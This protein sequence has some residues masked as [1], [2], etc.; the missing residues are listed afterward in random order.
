VAGDVDEVVAVAEP[1][2]PQLRDVPW[3]Q[4][5]LDE[6]GVPQPRRRRRVDAVEH[7]VAAGPVV[8]VVDVAPGRPPHVGVERDQQLRAVPADLRGHL[9]ADRQGRL[10]VP[11]G[12]TEEG[13]VVDAERRGR[14]ALLGLAD[15]DQPLALHRRV[16]G[17]AGAVGEHQVADVGPHPDQSRDRA[18][19]P[20]LRVVGVRDDHERPAERADRFPQ[21][22][23]H[24]ARA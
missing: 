6:G 15:A 2:H 17:A 21:R 3:L 5:L 11:V 9:A 20:E 13:D 8:G 18:A 10:E 4:A 1:R 19:C 24:R 7:E 22:R 16:S 12:V 14:R 23:R